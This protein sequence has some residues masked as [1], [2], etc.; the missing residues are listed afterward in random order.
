MPFPT[1]SHPP[2]FT[3]IPPFEGLLIAQTSEV[4]SADPTPPPQYQSSDPWLPIVGALLSGG[5]LSTAFIGF[6]SRFG[7]NFL[8]SQQSRSDLQSQIKKTE[9][10]LALSEEKARLAQTKELFDLVLDSLKEERKTTKGILDIF[11]TKFLNSTTEGAENAIAQQALLQSLI[12]R[13]GGFEKTLDRIDN[14]MRDIFD[15][16]KIEKRTNA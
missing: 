16:L 8:I 13:L 3:T 6:W 9:S 7:N 10:D 2:L 5:V 1:R 12:E 14:D 4:R 15:A 11:I